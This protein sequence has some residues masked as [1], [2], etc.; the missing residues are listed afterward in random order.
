[1]SILDNLR[2]ANQKAQQL[3]Q[4]KQ[5]REAII[6]AETA[7]KLWAEKPNLWERLLGKFLVG[8]VIERLEKQLINWRKQVVQADKIVAQA[9]VM[10]RRD[11]GDPLEIQFLTS[12]IDLYRLYTQIICDEWTSQVIEECQQILSQRKEFKSLISQAKSHAENRFF[13][14]AII[15]YKKAEKLYSTQIIRQAISALQIQVFQEEIYDSELQK[16]QQIEQEGKLRKAITILNSALTN[17]PRHDGFELLKNLQLKLQGRELFRQGLAA[18]K[19]SDLPAAKSLYENAKTLLV[20]SS[21]CQIRLGLVAIKMQ[22]WTNALFY[23]QG[24]SGKQAAYLRGFALAQQGNLDSA[25]QE[26]QGISEPTVNEQRELIKHISQQQRLLSLQK[27]EELVNTKNLEAAKV[28]SRKFLQRFGTESLVTTN[29]WEHIQ[30]SLAAAVWQD[31]NWENIANNTEKLWVNNANITTLHNWTVATYYHAQ[32]NQANLFDLI[33]ALSTSLAN[34]T[35]DPHLKNIPWLENGE[36]NFPAVSLELKQHLEAAI[37]QVKNINIEDYLDFYLDLRDHYRRELVALRLMGEPSNSGMKINDVF[38]TPGCYHRFFAQWE[39]NFIENIDADQKILR[40]LYTAWGLAVAAC[41]EGDSQ[42]AIQLKPTTK[43]TIE[44]EVFA[45]NLIAYHDACYQLQQ[46]NWRGAIMPLQ[47][48][49]LAIT[50]HQDWQQEINRLCGL[51]RQV[52]S[53]FS[54]HLEFAE[55]WYDILGNSKSARIYF[56]EYKAEEIRQQLVN[57]QI[58]LNQALGKLQK[59]QKIESSNP[60]VADMIEN[61]ELSQELKQINQLF[62]T[63]Q[64]EEMLK[65]A[66]LSK[67][68]KIRYIVAEFFINMLIKGIQEGRLHDPALMLQLGSWAYEICPHEPAFQEIYQNLKLS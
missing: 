32:D 65:T 25:N 48:I 27:I 49:K 16:A 13:K 35:A 44:I 14:Q 66:K 31:S 40:C 59:L 55:F 23:L 33:I 30:P 29:L 58:S 1:M 43:S 56:A 34:L 54:E 36:V 5:L 3:A 46:Q 20:N 24:L 62:Q 63:R 60:V 10:L 21:D 8:S 15:I 53:N 38:I 41:L 67:R 2:E 39:N 64:Y 61:V 37:D 52:I 9:Q 42:R 18:E 22:D 68:D 4:K 12:A 26:W 7:L 11:T 17:F 47:S 57:E 50:D 45:E 28:E 51:Q 6:T 19:S